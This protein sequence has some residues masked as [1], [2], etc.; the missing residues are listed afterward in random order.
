MVRAMFYKIRTFFSSIIQSVFGVFL[1][2]VIEF[3]KITISIKDL[4]GKLI[5]VMTT[6]M[7]TIDGSLLTMKSTW[8]G[9]PGQMV[10]AL[11][12]CFHPTTKIRLKNGNVVF[13]KDINLGDVLEDGSIVESTLKIDNTRNPVQM[14]KITGFGVN[15]QDIFVTGSHLVLDKDTN[16]FI[17][18][19]NYSKAK[20]TGIVPPWFSCLITSNHKI[21]IGHETFWDWEDHF[22]KFKYRSFL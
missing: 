21:V 16:Q 11:G 8:N 18:V 1:N 17:S 4:I 14:Y 13:I 10:Q 5:G 6:L 19:S 15:N 12:K 2:L 9:P 20:L 22:M 7:Y 3:Q